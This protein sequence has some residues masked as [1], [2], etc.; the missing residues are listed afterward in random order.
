MFSTS[1]VTSA[2][3]WGRLQGPAQGPEE[4]HYEVERSGTATTG[5][6]LTPVAIR[7]H[8]IPTAKDPVKRDHTALE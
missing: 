3:P 4:N 1:T 2:L 6:V 8:E 5:V 7:H